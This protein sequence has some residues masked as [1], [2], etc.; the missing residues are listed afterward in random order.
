[1]ADIGR[2]ASESTRKFEKDKPV[3]ATFAEVVRHLK[4]EKEKM[5]RA[6]QDDG[7]ESTIPSEW[8]E[9]EDDNGSESNDG[10][11]EEESVFNM[12]DQKTS[13]DDQVEEMNDRDK[14]KENTVENN[15]EKDQPVIGFRP[16]KPG[17]DEGV[18]EL[19]WK[20]DGSS[21]SVSKRDSTIPE[22]Q[23]DGTAA[24]KFRN[25]IL[26]EKKLKE[27]EGMGQGNGPEGNKSGEPNNQVEDREPHNSY[28]L[29]P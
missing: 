24:A 1:M 19:Q 29:S 3:A 20:G 14:I 10:W 7:E 15:L 8:S 26:C 25:P 28:G 23:M 21:S 5:D 16:E 9:G 18:E 27:K 13:K 4:D 17:D 2:Q 11:L 12:K 6:S 22:T